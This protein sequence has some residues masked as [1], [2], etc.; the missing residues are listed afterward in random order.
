MI[1]HQPTLHEDD[2]SITYS[3][4]HLFDSLGVDVM[5][6]EIFPHFEVET[7]H[8]I[9]TLVSKF[10]YVCVCLYRV[11]FLSLR[12]ESNI[13]A[14]C[15]NS[16]RMVEVNSLELM[17]LRGETLVMKRIFLSDKCFPNRFSSLT[18]L[19]FYGS[20]IGD[21]SLKYLTHSAILPNL[22]E[23]DLYHNNI[24]DKGMKSICEGN[25][26]LSILK[27]N[28]NRVGDLGFE[29]LKNS[30]ILK[31]N[32]KELYMTYNEVTS[33]GLEILSGMENSRLETLVLVSNRIESNITN[34]CAS[35]LASQLKHLNLSNNLL[36]NSGVLDICSG[37]FQS[38]ETLILSKNA[39]PKE[40]ISMLFE[41]SNGLNLKKLKHLDLYGNDYIQVDELAIPTF[42][43]LETLIFS[44]SY[45]NPYYH[46]FWQTKQ[47][48]AN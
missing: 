30:Q 11:E 40:S 16:P 43:S 39:I 32:L 37:N 35:S 4:D 31:E 18:S 19:S 24:T 33:K 26:K 8:S 3:N 2:E 6:G 22:T 48:S 38:L 10:W 20:K 21:S 7:L 13:L 9:F 14:L 1:Q 34:F 17:Q 44:H 36:G 15:S 46:L 28:L 5:I 25:L 29:F 45:R 12:G 23:L 41:S 42:N 27:L 47:F